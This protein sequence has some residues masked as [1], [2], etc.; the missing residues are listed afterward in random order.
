MRHR[1]IRAL[2]AVRYWMVRFS[3]Y[4]VPPENLSKKHKFA[5]RTWEYSLPCDVEG[6][7]DRTKGSA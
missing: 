6:W 7:V 1:A 4:G 2:L 3:W 5:W